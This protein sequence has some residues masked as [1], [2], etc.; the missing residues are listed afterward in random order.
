MLAKPR[1]RRPAPDL[2][3][4]IAPDDLA[5]DRRAPDRPEIAPDTPPESDTSP[6]DY[7]WEIQR[8][9]A[10]MTALTGRGWR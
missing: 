8:L 9:D 3:T 2:E 5:D 7:E 10:A 4:N 6:G 1:R